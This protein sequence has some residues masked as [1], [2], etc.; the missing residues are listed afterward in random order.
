MAGTDN[1]AWLGQAARRRH[2]QALAA[3]TAAIET[4]DR[5]AQPINFSTVATAAGVSRSWRYTQPEIR[6]LIT[7]LR[8][9]P[10]PSLAPSTQRASA[11]SLRQR[12]D[13]AR[14]EISRLRTDNTNLKDQIARHLGAQRAHPAPPTAINPR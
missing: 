5:H 10:T 6:D 4:L 14:D 13:A 3:A 12:L 11:E 1:S 2:H 7:R 9:A 8:A